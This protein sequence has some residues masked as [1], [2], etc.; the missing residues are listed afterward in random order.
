M[1]VCVFVA[2]AISGL[3][4]RMSAPE[5]EVV[6]FLP[7]DAIILPR[8]I[9]RFRAWR[10]SEAG[11]FT[12]LCNFSVWQIIRRVA[13]AACVIA[14]GLAVVISGALDRLPAALL[15]AIVL[16]SPVVMELIQSARDIRNTKGGPAE[17]HAGED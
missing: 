7:L 14:I 11:G 15:N 17:A 9:N 6:A 4:A 3:L 13:Q 10:E 12:A 2:L 1:E 5:I 8:V 16:A